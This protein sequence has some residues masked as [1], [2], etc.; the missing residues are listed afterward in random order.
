VTAPPQ[1]PP[2]E[3]LGESPAARELRA[4][5]E[6]AA[7]ADT[8]VLLE[9]PV[10][11][12][13]ELAARFVHASGRRR[14]GPFVVVPC[15]ALAP[16]LAESELF[17]HEK[18]AFTGATEP[19]TGLVE[20]ASGG[21]VFFAE[22][23]EL[24]LT[25]QAKL[26]RFFEDRTVT[27]LGAA[28]ARPVDVRVV[29][30][31]S[32][33]LAEEVRRG[34][35]REDLYYRMRVLSIEVPPLAERGEDVVLLAGRFLKALSEDAGR[36][37]PA[38]SPDARAALLRHPW[39][40]NVRELQNTLR[41]ALVF[42]KDVSPAGGGAGP[43]VTEEDLDL[44]EPGREAGVGGGTLKASVARIVREAETRIIAAALERSDGNRTQAAK[45]LGLSRRGLQLKM[46][47]YGLR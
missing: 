44:E 42:A 39:P 41:A 16:Q 34:R 45:E 25:V 5:C 46:K 47:R 27:P 29:A 3:I 20:R 24:P 1:P 8:V 35:F 28:D 38:L 22:V 37:A 17:G 23:G 36:K 14:G 2:P 21:T 33:D 4:R 40:G 15:A 18:G 13:R 9:G 19:H 11:S 26:L 32:L 6:A 7:A 30:S 10:G 12:G 43:V 31:T